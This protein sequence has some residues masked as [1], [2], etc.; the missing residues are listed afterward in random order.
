MDYNKTF[1]S[2]CGAFKYAMEKYPHVMAAEFQTAVTMCDIQ[3][4][5]IVLNIPA[6]CIPLADYFNQTPQKYIEYETNRTF[7]NLIGIKHAEFFEI[8]ELPTSVSKLISLASLHHA[9]TEERRAFYAEAR[10][11]V[12]PSGVLIIGDVITGSPQA[13]W[14]N[15]FVNTY[16]PQG[17]NGV[18]WSEDDCTLLEATGFTTTCKRVAYTWNFNNVDEMVDFVRNLFGVSAASDNII[19]DGVKKYLDA[20]FHPDG[21]VQFPWQ[22]IYFHSRPNS[23]SNFMEKKGYPAAGVNVNSLK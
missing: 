2:R 9:T 21:T 20:V 14:L 13:S 3:P 6:A 19:I 15:D 16:N 7:A 11:I 5:D 18:F 23:C 8:P 10:R 17:H 12:D 1:E 4:T 22:L